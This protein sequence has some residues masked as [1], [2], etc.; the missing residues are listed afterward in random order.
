MGIQ[1]RELRLDEI[2]PGA[3]LDSEVRDAHGQLLLPGGTRITEAMLAELRRHSILTLP[4]LVETTLAD[5]ERIDA[6]D[7]NL[8][9]IRYIF[10]GAGD[11]EP[12]C[13]L[14]RQVAAYRQR[15]PS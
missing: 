7:H 8:Q 13:E 12:L 1:S 10:R 4:V 11:S 5:D 2:V 6:I 3:V 15:K 14:E 9:R